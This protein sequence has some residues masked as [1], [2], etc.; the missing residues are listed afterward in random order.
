MVV[1]DATARELNQHTAQVLARAEGGETVTV[2]RNGR[3]V[4]VIRGYRE[5][6]PQAYPFRTDP[7]G[8]DESVPTFNGPPDFAER[9]D[10]LLTGFGGDA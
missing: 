4:A 6:Y 8:I 9:T 7:M 3:P 10:D 5:D 2:T 1:V